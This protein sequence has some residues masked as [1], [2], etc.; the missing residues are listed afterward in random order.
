[1]QV[2]ILIGVSGSGKSTWA[3]NKVACLDWQRA[4]TV[5]ADQYFTD[6][7]TGIYHFEPAKLPAAHAQCLRNYVDALQTNAN[8]IIVDNTNTSLIE[9][10]PYVA[11]AQAYGAELQLLYF[12]VGLHIAAVR[13]MHGVPLE[14]IERMAQS[15]EHLIAFECPPWWP[16]P[17]PQTY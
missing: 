14:V 12:R 4:V 15:M 11:L 10:A 5:S 1:M 13:N 7:D 3:K 8:L 2:Y 17:Q 9:L 16:Q 6:R